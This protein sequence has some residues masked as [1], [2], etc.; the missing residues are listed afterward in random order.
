MHIMMNVDSLSAYLVESGQKVSILKS[1]VYAI[2]LEAGQPDMAATDSI[3][4]AWAKQFVCVNLDLRKSF[5]QNL[6]VHRSLEGNK[7]MYLYKISIDSF[8]RTCEISK[9]LRKNYKQS[10]YFQ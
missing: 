2:D 4:M 7:Y 1:I 10:L 6:K 3:S 8:I 5:A 9:N